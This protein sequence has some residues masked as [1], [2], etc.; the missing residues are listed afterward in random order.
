MEPDSLAD[1]RSVGCPQINRTT[2]QAA[3]LTKKIN[4]WEPSLNPFCVGTQRLRARTLCVQALN[5]TV[6]LSRVS[7]N[8]ARLSAVASPLAS[9]P[10][11]FANP[12]RY[13]RTRV[14]AGLVRD[15]TA[16]YERGDSMR[17]IA[18]TLGIGKAT[19]VKILNAADV[20]IKPAG[21][22]Y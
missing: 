19:V 16:R 10:S 11:R 9:E 1:R 4:V 12:R 20:P 7:L 22:H 15:V 21:R 2:T 6:V 17:T 13:V 18:L 14:T 5:L 8:I 3:S